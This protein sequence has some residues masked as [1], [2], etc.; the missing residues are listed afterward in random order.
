MPLS[1]LIPDN[2]GPLIEDFE[3]EDL[4]S[5][6]VKQRTWPSRSILFT[7]EN[8]V[9]FVIHT[10]KTPESLPD[11]VYLSAQSLGDLDEKDETQPREKEE[12][13]S[14]NAV[15]RYPITGSCDVHDEQESV[16]IWKFDLPVGYTRGGKI[17]ITVST[18]NTHLQAGQTAAENVEKGHVVPATDV[19]KS[20]SDNLFEELNFRVA[21]EKQPRYEFSHKL[22]ASSPGNEA[23]LENT[24]IVQ[25]ANE[26]EA[27][28]T[29]VE[30]T[31]FLPL[32][33]KLRSTKPS[34]RNDILLTTLGI[35]PSAEM[36]AYIEKTGHSEKY[37]FTILALEATFKG[38][39]IRELSTFSFPTRCSFH[40]ILNVSY[41]LVNTEYLDGHVNNTNE[42]QLASSKPLHLKM[43]A[44][45][46]SI[47]HENVLSDRSSEIHTI[48]SPILEFGLVAPPISDTLKKGAKASHFVTQ[49]QFLAS[50]LE[51]SGPSSRKALSFNNLAQPKLLPTPQASSP[52]L[53]RGVSAASSPLISLTKNASLS[54]KSQKSTVSIPASSPSAVTVNVA[55]SNS[56]LSGLR[57]TFE[58]SLSVE[59]GKI[60]TWKIQAIN[61]TAKALNLSIIVKN[62]NRA[63]I[64]NNGSNIYGLGVSTQTL[65]LEQDAKRPQIQNRAQLYYQYSSS[66][67]SREGVIVLSNDIRLGPLD[68]HGVFESEISLIGISKG[69]FNLDGLKVIDLSTR[70]GIEFGKLV[71][72]FVV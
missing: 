66:K 40:D 37:Y 65:P 51:K 26:T 35:E 22:A 60:S 36:L 53:G 47:D 10:A 33:L 9:G 5:L 63:P 16:S 49:S 67:L 7:E 17:K 15:L 50:P 23:P 13:S 62:S 2:V 31:T 21:G 44:K 12:S 27:E 20:L 14:F 11:T 68:P 46:Q 58:G 71:E 6:Y 70:D 3:N 59:L 30:L 64:E 39:K 45:I 29:S 55:T 18:A 25:D 72:V 56:S 28:S 42:S 34:G 43:S 24:S 19:A 1:I 41:R 69:V 57:L 52:H 32:V 4:D 48:W 38:E 61:Q 8:V 54:K